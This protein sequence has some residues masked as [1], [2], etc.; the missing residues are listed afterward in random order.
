MR[1][2]TSSRR[3]STNFELVIVTGNDISASPPDVLN[4]HVRLVLVGPLFYLKILRG[5]TTQV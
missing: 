2:V 5:Q 4:G 1:E 3:L